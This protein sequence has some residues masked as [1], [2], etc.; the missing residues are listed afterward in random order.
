MPKQI[1]NQTAAT[2]IV[3]ENGHPTVAFFALL[4]GLVNLEVLDGDGSPEGVVEADPKTLY[5]DRSGVAGAILYVKRDAQ[6]GSGN[7]SNGWILI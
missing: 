1:I 4:E 7:K 6:D 3:D 2:P 5:M